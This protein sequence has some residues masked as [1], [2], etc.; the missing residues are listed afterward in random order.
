[1]QAGAAALGSARKVQVAPS[2]IKE[3]REMGQALEA[4][5]SRRAAQEE[6]R[7]RLL[8]SLEEALAQARQAGQ[9][10]DAFLAMLG[11]EL[12]NPLSP[13]LTSLDL[14]D[15]RGEAGSQRERAVMRRQVT[16]LRRL[17]DDL[18]DVSRI[19]SGKLAID[20]RPLNLAELAR[21]A[22]AALPGEPITLEAPPEVWVTGD[23]TRLAQVLGNLLSNAARF[24]S[25]DTRV[26]LAAVNGEAVLGVSDNGA[27]MAPELLARVFEPFYQAPQPLARRTGGLGLGLAIVR[28]IAQLH[29]G[30]VAAYSAGPGAGSHF[31]V[32]L[33]LGA[34]SA[35][36]EPDPLAPAAPG[37]RILLV[38]DNED[39]A[40]A[41][42]LLLRHLGHAVRVAH[43]AAE[44]RALA[45]AEPPE[46]AILDIGL[47]DMDG[48]ALAA[49]LRGDAGAPE[50]GPLR[51]VALTGYG[52]QADVAR[53]LA[54]GFDVHLTKPATIEALQDAVAPAAA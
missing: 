34:P 50:G 37:R 10:K 54:A 21:H 38:D 24:G 14:M 20:A 8:A 30:R 31:E 46:V 17:V 2:R 27:G 6:E 39:A 18:L 52:Q 35:A 44:A 53:A 7:S 41:S 42:A 45:V 49:A 4:A 19:A 13:I 47:P 5:A 12:R 22:V 23:E 1:V 15:L 11:H 40:A 51:L 33:P 26:T 16:H 28:E 29:G 32:I 9:A 25:S 3:I 36:R 48:Y 43:S